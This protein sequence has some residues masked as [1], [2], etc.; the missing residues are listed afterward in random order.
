M[1]DLLLVSPHPEWRT[2]V[3]QLEW[4]N[5]VLG[6]NLWFYSCLD[7]CACVCVCHRL[8][9]ARYRSL[10]L[11]AQL[12]I[13]QCSFRMTWWQYCVFSSLWPLWGAHL[14]TLGASQPPTLWCLL[15]LLISTSPGSQRSWHHPPGAHCAPHHCRQYVTF[16]AGG[17]RWGRGTKKE[18]RAKKRKQVGKYVL[19]K[20]LIQKG[21][22]TQTRHFL[23][24]RAPYW[25]LVTSHI[26]ANVKVFLS[27]RVCV[28]VM[29]SMGE[30]MP[31]TSELI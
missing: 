20:L 8:A 3:G 30:S 14:L 25:N 17:G 21:T 27:T 11:A 24:T 28:C 18:E 26:Q 12:C 15:V 23:S 9:L 5:G 19:V 6:K 22:K 2:A 4:G 10:S 31:M 16:S 29:T 1:G 13:K 7:V